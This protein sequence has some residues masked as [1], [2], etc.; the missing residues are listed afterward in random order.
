MFFRCKCLFNVKHFSFLKKVL[1]T[2][3]DVYFNQYLFYEIIYLFSFFHL[4]DS[5]AM[6]K[7]FVIA[8]SYA[9]EEGCFWKSLEALRS[10][11]VQ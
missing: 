9:R 8:P 3:G 11:Y 5:I 7:K 2:M 1:S 6:L 10:F 4:L